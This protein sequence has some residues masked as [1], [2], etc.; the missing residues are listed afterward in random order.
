MIAA[1]PPPIRF[2]PRIDSKR[3]RPSGF[4]FKNARIQTAKRNAAAASTPA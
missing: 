4:A 3:R 1:R 2:A